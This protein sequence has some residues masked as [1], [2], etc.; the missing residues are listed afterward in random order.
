MV[1]FIL[2]GDFMNYG[3]IKVAAATPEIRV[4]DCLSNKEIIIN[5]IAEANK[6]GASVIVFP[7]LSV[8]GATCG[9]L[10]FHKSFLKSC[11][12]AIKEIIDETSDLNIVSIIGTPVEFNNRL[13]NCGAVISK[14]ELLGLVPKTNIPNPQ[15]RYFASGEDIDE[16]INYAECETSLSTSV[17]K[18]S[19]ID[20][21]AFGVEIS[22][23]LCGLYPP[24]SCLIS[25]G[26]NIIFNLASFNELVGQ[27]EYIECLVNAQ[28]SKGICAY[29]I[30]NAGLGESTTDFVYSGFSYIYENG[31]LISNSEKFSKGII[32]GDIDL[33]IL[34]SLKRRN[35]SL[36]NDN[37][38][39]ETEFEIEP[40]E[41]ILSRC[42]SPT[43]FIPN[44]DNYD[45]CLEDISKT[46]V[47]GLATR[48]KHTGIKNVVLGI[49]GGLDSTLAII[50]CVNTFKYL[51][52]DLKNIHAISMPCFGT[53][54][55]T[56]SNA[57]K[58]CETY[59]VTFKE[60]NISKSVLEHFEAI[61]HN[62]DLYDV[63]YENSQARERTQVL[64]DVAN[65]CNGLV[66]GTGDLS[67]LA[68]GWATYNGD[69]MSM[70]GINGSIPK[71]LIRH[72][73]NFEA[74]KSCGPLKEALIDVLNTPVS[75][76]LLPPKENGEIA[77]ITEDVVGPY[78]LHDFF[79]YYFVR[80][81][82][83]LK[84]IFY[85]AQK[86]FKDKYDSEIIKKWLTIFVT[87]FF[88]QQ[89]KRN[90]LPD[91]PKVGTVSLSPR[92]DLVLPSDS[93]VAVWLKE[94]E[95]L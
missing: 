10:L 65:Q 76:E 80:Y 16:T 54:N 34:S 26:A 42:I 1:Y 78:E 39:N 44:D 60:I 14:G 29:V 55:R 24:S 59:G 86:A 27:D 22:E 9:D 50:A 90:C 23:D 41:I 5:Q 20:N 64:M 83:S 88:R 12:L 30:S 84:K 89:F 6:E 36:D 87:R 73:V 75:P 93:S 18:C 4:A 62:K 17:F 3:F 52:Y 72:L 77:Q 47:I 94:L 68:L 81:N 19:T 8:C 43:P 7:E 56:K 2:I 66:V 51:N 35:I 21:L 46:Q 61:N 79:L 58:I 91:G 95:N 70:Y 45:S 15:V 33:E 40:K 49:S 31:K 37:C 92:G 71:T 63:T 85:L 57:Q 32:Y 28:S 74:N 38:I 25:C 48:L 13:Y 11:E 53:T 82:S 69:H 67:E